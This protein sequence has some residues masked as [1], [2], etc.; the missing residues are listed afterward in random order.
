MLVGSLLVLVVGAYI[1]HPEGIKGIFSSGFL[2]NEKKESNIAVLI[3][4]LISGFAYTYLCSTPITVFH[5]GRMIREGLNKHAATFWRYWYGF[6]SVALIGLVVD[7]V[8]GFAYFEPY[9]TNVLLFVTSLPALWM[10]IGQCDVIHRIKADKDKASDSTFVQYYDRLASSRGTNEKLKELRES[11]THL[12]EHANSVFICV[13]EI[14]VAA[15]VV[16]LWRMRINNEMF[17]MS[18]LVGVLL[19]IA[20]NIF[21]WSAANRLERHL[22]E[23]APPLESTKE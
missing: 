18:C 6:S 11:Y 2:W 23:C 17:I 4:I 9:R 3:G 19:W 7:G 5:A 16:L 20:P 8:S 13:T 22:I 1:G 10:F 15:L 21:L 12:R 14:S